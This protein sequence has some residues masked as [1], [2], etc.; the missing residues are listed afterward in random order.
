MGLRVSK[1]G[2]MT[3]ART[4]TIVSTTG[5]DTTKVA[6]GK[7]DTDLTAAFTSLNTHNALTATHGATALFS[8]DDLD[9]TPTAD[10]ADGMSSNWANTHK[11]LTN[12]SGGIQPRVGSVASSATPTINTDLYD[13]Y[14]I[15]ALAANIT[16][17]TTNLSGTPGNFQQLIIRIK[18]NGVA[19]TIAWGAKFC[20]EGV[21]LP[22]TTK[23]SKVMTVFFFYDS[24]NSKWGCVGVSEE[25]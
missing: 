24:V 17:F 6:I 13:I 8:T 22:T 4:T 14:S 16:S 12:T 5:G 19:R 1:D 11:V 3:Y 20:D 2:K 25:K 10:T 9:E 18:D 23:A 21:P 7:V 15:T